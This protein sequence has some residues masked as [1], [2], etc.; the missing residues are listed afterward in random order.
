[1][2]EVC[3]GRIAEVTAGIV[4]EN[5]WLMK[6][7]ANIPYINGIAYFHDQWCAIAGI[8]DG[9]LIKISIIPATILTIGGSKQLVLQE[10]I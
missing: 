8:S 10:I 4:S 6:S 1:M 2:R 9:L 7:F 5:S 3:A